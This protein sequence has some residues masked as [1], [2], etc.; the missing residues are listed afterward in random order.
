MHTH[1]IQK[2]ANDLSATSIHPVVGPPKSSVTPPAPILI[3][4]SASSVLFHPAP[5]HPDK[6][7]VGYYILYGRLAAGSNVKVR[8]SDHDAAG[9]GVE[10][11]EGYYMHQL[12][13][14]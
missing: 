10:V 2:A 9:L 7:D 3:H 4:Q 13:P 1:T 14:I 8:L 12:I 11:R 5:Y 6:V